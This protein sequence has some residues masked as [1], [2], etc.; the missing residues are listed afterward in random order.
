MLVS[1]AAE[2]T[3]ARGADPV[4]PPSA[5]AR[6]RVRDDASGFDNKE[7]RHPSTPELLRVLDRATTS[8][9]LKRTEEALLLW[10]HS[11]PKP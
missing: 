7:D 1:G 11:T 6:P 4:G 8:N 10:F 5:H 9:T 2:A 3:E